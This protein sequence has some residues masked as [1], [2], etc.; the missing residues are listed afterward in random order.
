MDNETIEIHKQSV[1]GF[2]G[3]SGADI[4]LKWVIEA[5]KLKLEFYQEKR[6]KAELEENYSYALCMSSDIHSIMGVIKCLGEE[7]FYA[8]VEAVSNGNEEEEGNE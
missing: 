8:L 1:S 4:G 2:L 5:L 7:R 6:L 3:V